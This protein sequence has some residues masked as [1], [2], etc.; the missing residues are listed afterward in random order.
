MAGYNYK[1]QFYDADHK[2]FPKL[3]I[4]GSENGHHL[5]AW[6]AVTGNEY[7]SGQFL[8]TGID[9]LGEARG[10]PV[11][12]S[13]AGIL[14]LAGNEKP[15]YRRRKILWNNEGD[16]YLA[17]CIKEGIS[18]IIQPWDVSRSWNYLPGA[19]ITVICYTNLDSAEL[20]VNGKSAGHKE[21]DPS[22]EYIP[23]QVPFERGK[24]EARGK[25]GS[26]VISDAME[27]TLPPTRLRLT[28]WEAPPASD[29]FAGSPLLCPDLRKPVQI[30]LEVLD[31]QDRLCAAERLMVEVTVSDGTKLLGIENGDISDCTEYPAPRR[32]T[33][34]GRLIIYVLVPGGGKAWVEAAAEGLPKA[35]I[36]LSGYAG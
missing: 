12:G 7:I 14:D 18:K 26:A 23:W 15:G 1:E 32:E 4:I 10:W 29:N 8:W 11:R 20:F 25:N 28:R 9:F 34:H 36:E 19:E 16:L 22:L 33:F 30:E 27:S 13:G 17:T 21:R 31:E 35:K 2:R 6:K 5:A 24:I 3:P